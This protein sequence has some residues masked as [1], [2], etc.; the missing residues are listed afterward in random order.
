MSK[1]D[2]KKLKGEALFY[3][4]TTDHPDKDYSSIVSMLPYATMDLDKAYSILERCIRENK[5]LIAVYPGEEK[6]DTSGMEYVGS[7]HDGG[8]Y[9]K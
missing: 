1:I 8:L 7:I 6:T 9:I 4:F 2:Y 5:I 3:Y